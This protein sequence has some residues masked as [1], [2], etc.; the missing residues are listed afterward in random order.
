MV[1][2]LSGMWLCVVWYNPDDEGSKYIRNS[3]NILL[4]YMC[5]IPLDNNLQYLLKVLY[6]HDCMKQSPCWESDGSST[7][8]EISFF[9]NYENIHKSPKLGITCARRIKS[10]YKY[11]ICLKTLSPV[12]QSDSHAV[13]AF[14]VSSQITLYINGFYG[15][16]NQ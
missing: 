2:A 6:F 9:I 3:G 4:D 16:E 13:S 11:Y 8:R 15:D 1:T 14:D 7:C 5:H 12:V 10:I